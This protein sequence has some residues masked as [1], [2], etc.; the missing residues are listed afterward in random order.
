MMGGA[1]DT[2]QRKEKKM[3]E[4]TIILAVMPEDRSI[5][6]G[7]ALVVTG[8]NIRPQSG[9]LLSIKYTVPGLMG[10]DYLMFGREVSI[11]QETPITEGRTK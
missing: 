9:G 1:E 3:A 4:K 7:V 6:E 2:Q 8:F 5:T 10:S 11:F